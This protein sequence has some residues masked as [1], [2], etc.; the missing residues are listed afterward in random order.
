MNVA[1]A[2]GRLG[3]W[4]GLA[5]T[6]AGLFVAVLIGAGVLQAL[7]PMPKA[8]TAAP[9]VPLPAPVPEP[10]PPATTPATPPAKVGVAGPEAALLE[11]SA[12]FSGAQL[13]RIAPDGRAPRT[14]YA[15]PAPPTSTPRI[16]ILMSGFGLSAK[17]SQNAIDTLPGPVSFAVSAYAGMGIPELALARAQG[18]E[19]LV[20]LPMEP[21]G[22]PLNDAGTRSLLTG[23]SPAENRQNLEWALARVPGAVGVTGASDGMRGERFSDLPG[24]FDP[25]LDEIGRRGLLYVDARS[26][27]APDRPGLPARAI[28]VVL[29]DPPARAEIEAKLVALE[30]VARE[31]GTAIG[32]A[33]PVRPVTVERIAAWA[34]TLP[35]RGLT[36]VPVSSLVM[37]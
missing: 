33:G 35:A 26:G 28:S 6:W 36:L 12:V 14:I 21:Q 13:P 9:P 4:R 32:L 25:V 16:A 15:A 20:S 17:E 7:G 8:I 11:R 23:L 24:A 5:L 18:H 27:R 10:V 31:R 3:A 2:I 30:R 1:T 34:K 22:Y 37:P 19:L 29:D